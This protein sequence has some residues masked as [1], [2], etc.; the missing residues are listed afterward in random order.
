MNKFM[1]EE[2]MREN[3]RFKPTRNDS[4]NKSHS[5]INN[6]VTVDVKEIIEFVKNLNTTANI[7]KTTAIRPQTSNN[8]TA[9]K[10]QKTKYLT[11]AQQVIFKLLQF[12]HIHLIIAQKM[13]I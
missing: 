12:K 7:V 4:Q 10:A 11:I 2:C 8:S 6:R 3:K 1:I 13:K 9:N 5:S